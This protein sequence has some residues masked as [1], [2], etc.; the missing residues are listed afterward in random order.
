MLYY[1]ILSYIISYYI[2]WYY[3]TLYYTILHYTILYYYILYY[4]TLYYI[5]VYYI[6]LYYIIGQGRD[7]GRLLRARRRARGRRAARDPEPAGHI[8]YHNIAYCTILVYY[9]HTHIHIY[10]YIYVYTY[11]HIFI[12]ICRQSKL[13][14][15][16]EL[17][18]KRGTLKGVPIVKSPASHF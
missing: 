17:S 7:P 13:A 16:S 11:I 5:T 14:C 1:I 10:I 12:Y 6:I 18:H 2:T 15:S 4:I 9:M 3:I 8:L